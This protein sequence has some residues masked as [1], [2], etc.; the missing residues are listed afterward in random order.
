MPQKDAVLSKIE[1]D[2]PFT[3]DSHGRPIVVGSIVRSFDF[4][5]LGEAAVEGERACF[6]EGEVIGVSR[7]GWDCPR[8]AIRPIRRVFA[9]KELPEERLETVFPPLNGTDAWLGGETKGVVVVE[10]DAIIFKHENEIDGQPIGPVWIRRAEE[11][12]PYR[13]HPTMRDLSD[14]PTAQWMGL[15]EA[16]AIAEQ[17]GLP[18]E[19][20]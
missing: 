13:E 19:E 12:K 16:T 5:G 2:L 10:P 1:S 11:S 6:V 7:D 17:E 15:D 14:N 9:G 8:Y 3:R 18:L 20:A 4:D